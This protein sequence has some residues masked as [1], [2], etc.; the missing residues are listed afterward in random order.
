M[1]ESAKVNWAVKEI[2][3]PQPTNHDVT[4]FQFS[5]GVTIH[6]DVQ[7]GKG[8][9]TIFLPAKE[10]AESIAGDTLNFNTN[11]QFRLAV[12]KAQNGVPVVINVIGKEV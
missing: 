12:S 9:L 5:N 10:V 7:D 1:T 11:D 3:Y 6:Y 4:E 8:D 2:N